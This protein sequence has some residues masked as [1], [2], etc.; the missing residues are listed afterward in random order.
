MFNK[1][2]LNLDGFLYLT[3]NDFEKTKV[4]EL[5]QKD[6]VPVYQYRY[7]DNLLLGFVVDKLCLPINSRKSDYNYNLNRFMNNENIFICT[8]DHFNCK[9]YSTTVSFKQFFLYLDMG[10]MS[11]NTVIMLTEKNKGVVEE[12]TKNDETS[13]TFHEISSVNTI[14][15]KLKRT[16]SKKDMTKYNQLDK[17]RKRIISVIIF[18]APILAILFLSGVIG[19]GLL[20]LACIFLMIVMEWSNN[21]L[22]RKCNNIL[23]K[24]NFRQM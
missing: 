15:D 19:F 16:V 11:I 14:E 4:L 2:G 13:D 20:M 9:Y 12:F 1:K 6:Y 5:I 8:F 17:I 21:V 24:Y 22:V 7:R 18:L 3:L 10:T 23:S